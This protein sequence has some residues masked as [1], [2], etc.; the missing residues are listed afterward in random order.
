[1]PYQARV[2]DDIYFRFKY[3]LG[4]HEILLSGSVGSAKSILMAHLA[5]RHCIENPGAKLLLGRKALPDLKETI[6]RKIL[7]HLEG[8]LVEGVH[9]SINT[10]QAG[11]K[12]RNGS[13]I[14]S[15]SWADKAYKKM[16]SL[17]LSAAI[18]EELTENNQ[19]DSQA[20]Q[21]IKM[22][23][24]RLP[25]IKTN[26]IVAATNPDAPDHWVY[27]YFELDKSDA[28]RNHTRHVYY[29]VTTDNPF[30]PSQ[31]VD[32]LRADLDP[33]MARRMIFGEWLSI[34]TEVIYYAYDKVQNRRG[35]Y[36]VDL[37]LPIHITFDFNI[38]QGKPLSCAC[39]QYDKATDTFHVFDEV[40]V[41]GMRTED[42]LEEL[43]DKGILDHRTTYIVNGDASGKHRD[44]RNIKSDYEIIRVFLSNYRTQDGR[45]IQH[46]QQVP[47]ANPPIRK[48][49]N[50]VNAYCCNDQGKRRL[51]VYEKA[52]TADEALR[53]SSL[54]KGAGLLEDDS[55]AFQHIGTSIGYCLVETIKRASIPQSQSRRL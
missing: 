45:T 43:A 39:I 28:E 30:L 33:L 24:G 46:E 1:M 11:I 32:Q 50:V 22:R 26:W 40:V 3:E 41:E 12:F 25:H 38:G 9:Y 42:A 37:R 55:K 13:E 17:E 5:V 31:Y 15:R 21:E 44:T 49:H 2:I 18:I 34:Q 23:V 16:R 51:F 36:E 19:D 8:S 7:E 4:V 48:R 54:K 14:I 20:Y 35:A 47:L 10:T 52:K 53:L 29:S 6:Y 27:K